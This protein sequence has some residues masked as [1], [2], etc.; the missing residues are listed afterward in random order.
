MEFKGREYGQTSLVLVITLGML[1][2]SFRVSLKLRFFLQS[3]S[4]YSIVQHGTTFALFSFLSIFEL[5]I[6]TH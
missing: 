6:G 3:F 5:L 1:T 4:F 2:L